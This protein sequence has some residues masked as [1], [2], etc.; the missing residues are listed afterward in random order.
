MPSQP[1][2]SPQLVRFSHSPRAA[3]GHVPW[4]P[5]PSRCRSGPSALSAARQ[6]QPSPQDLV[7]P[8]A[9]S[10]A[11]PL[12][13]SSPSLRPRNPPSLHCPEASVLPS[14]PPLRCPAPLPPDVL[15]RLAPSLP[16]SVCLNCHLIGRLSLTPTVKNSLPIP[17]IL[18]PSSI[19]LNAVSHCWNLQ[20]LSVYLFVHLPPRLLG[21]APRPPTR[22]RLLVFGPPPCAPAWSCTQHVQG[23]R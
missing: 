10:H 21:R 17:F 11:S 1:G 22:Q 9:V 3:H 7:F 14:P 2:Q 20:C 6:L 18:F 19:S 23:V 4:A 15:P 8:G 13:S 12:P 5:C 16:L